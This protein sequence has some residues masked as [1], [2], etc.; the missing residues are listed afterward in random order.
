M[1]HIYKIYKNDILILTTVSDLNPEYADSTKLD[2]LLNSPSILQSIYADYFNFKQKRT[3]DNYSI[4]TYQSFES[5][6]TAI[7]VN[8]SL[9]SLIGTSKNSIIN[10]TTNKTKKPRAKKVKNEQS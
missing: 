7:E 8:Q 2:I 5:I 3:S 1:N 4:E 6:H 10:T 9:Q